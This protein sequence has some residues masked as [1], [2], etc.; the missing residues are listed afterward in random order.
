M[1]VL[2]EL[3]TR[4]FKTKQ[5]IALSYMSQFHMVSSQESAKIKPSLFNHGATITGEEEEKEDGRVGGEQEKQ[6]P[7]TEMWGNSVLLAS[8]P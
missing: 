8:T 6:E 1:V 2:I 3:A 4:T 5:P 7:H